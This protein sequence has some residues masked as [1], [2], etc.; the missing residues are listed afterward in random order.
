MTGCQSSACRVLLCSFSLDAPTFC[1][2]PVIIFRVSGQV[3]IELCRVRFLP[4]ASYS[5]FFSH[6]LYPSCLLPTHISS[7]A[8]TAKMT[9]PM[10]GDQAHPAA[11]TRK[12]TSLSSPSAARRL[13]RNLSGK[14]RTNPP[15]LEDGV[16]SG[17][18]GDKERLRKTAI[19]SQIDKV[20]K[21]KLRRLSCQNS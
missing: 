5:T 15:G 1:V 4:Q 21:L 14:F 17:R 20:R 8:D 13:Y 16:V 6:P 2:R 18:G 11:P 10:R 19:V 9:Q 7:R 3:K 12:S